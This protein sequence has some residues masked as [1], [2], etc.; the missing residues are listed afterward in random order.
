[1]QPQLPVVN[2]NLLKSNESIDFQQE[3]LRQ[4]QLKAQN[5]QSS[6]M[7]FSRQLQETR[8][9]LEKEIHRQLVENLLIRAQR[10]SVTPEQ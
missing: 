1:M 6:Q 10:K 4:A 7:E 3:D 5:V 9:A 2:Q 8:L